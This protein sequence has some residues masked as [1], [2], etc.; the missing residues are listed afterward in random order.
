MNEQLGP[1]VSRVSTAPDGWND[2]LVAHNEFCSKNG[3]APLFN[4]TPF[5]TYD[6]VR[7]ALGARIEKFV[8][9]RK[10]FD[11]TDRMLMPY[12]PEHLGE[13]TTVSVV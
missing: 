7:K 4:Q 6:Q 10:R 3:G 9:Y 1:Q 5:L 13:S 8:E 12:F 11:P 2:F